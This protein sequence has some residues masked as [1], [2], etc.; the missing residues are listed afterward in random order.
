MGQTIKKGTVIMTFDDVLADTSYA[1]YM[2]FA[3][4]SA[5]YGKMMDLM[6]MRTKDEVGSRDLE[7][8]PV[9]LLRKDLI[10][11]L[12]KEAVLFYV[13]QIYATEK[14]EFFETDYLDG[15]EPTEFA[16]RTLMNSGFSNSLAISKAVIAIRYRKMVSGDL[17]RK[18]AFCLR[19]FGKADGK[20]DILPIPEDVR[21]ED[22]IRAKYPRWDIVVT[23]DI[24]LVEG[25]AKGDIDHREFLMPSYGCDKAPDELCELIRVKS[26]SLSYYRPK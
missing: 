6:R 19:W 20:Y 4:N 13:S 16:K 12:P 22:A 21:P 17:D 26:S 23:D 1:Q 3:A 5:K 2:Y 18:K 7:N 24:S 14:R 8:V 11:G 25:L 10:S 15:V 9:W